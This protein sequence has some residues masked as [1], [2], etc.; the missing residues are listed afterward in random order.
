MQM[1]STRTEDVNRTFDL[2]SDDGLAYVDSAVTPRPGMEVRRVSV[3]LPQ[4]MIDSLDQEAARVGVA[5][6]AIIKVWLDE[7]LA[8]E[9]PAAPTRQ[10]PG[11]GGRPAAFHGW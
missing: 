2:G 4:W 5:R 1:Q 6:Q 7:R 10:R 3:D 9:R 8:Q 11:P